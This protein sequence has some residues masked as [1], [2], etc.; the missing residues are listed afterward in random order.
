MENVQRE[1]GFD[2][3]VPTP[4]PDGSEVLG[5]LLALNRKLSPFG[6]HD[7]GTCE[8]PCS[9]FV[10]RSARPVPS[11]GCQKMPKSPSRSDWN[12]TRSPSE[13]QMGNRFRP[14]NVSRR[15]ALVRA[16]S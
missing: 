9:G 2:A 1:N 15:I 11:A 6:D 4:N 7:S 16:R 13:D 14:P 12:A 5:P 10:R 3:I 8:V